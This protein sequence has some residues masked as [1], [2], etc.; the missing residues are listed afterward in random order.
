MASKN[1]QEKVLQ[2][3]LD[4]YNFESQSFKLTY[5][6]RYCMKKLL[7]FGSLASLLSGCANFGNGELTGVQNR[8]FFEEV[9]PMG[10]QFCRSGSYQMGPN[11]QDV[12]W[13][14]TAE[15]KT[16]SV[17]AFWIDQ[18][19]IT[20][21]EY[22]QFVYWVKDSIALKLLGELDEERYL[23][24]T[25]EFEEEVTP[26]FI[27]W[28]S[29]VEW[30]SADEEVR[31]AL[32]PM[33]LP[34]GE[35]FYRQ[36]QIDTRKLNFEY[37]WIDMR[38]AARKNY[39]G[40]ENRT[41][42]NYETQ[43]YDG[44]II[45]YSKGATRG[46]SVEVK[47]RSSYIMH[48]IINVYPD[49]LVWISDFTYSFNEPNAKA[50]FWHPVYDHYPVVGVTWRQARAFS[51]WRTNLLNSYLNEQEEP[52]V[53]DFRLPTESEWE[54]AAR[55]GQ[56]SSMYPW[57]GPYATNYKGCYIANFKP[58]RGNYP[59]DGGLHTVIVANNDPNDWGIYDMAGNVAEWTSNAFDESAYSFTDDLNP[60]Y[61]Y[62]TKPNDQPE[63]KR[64][65][66]RGGSWKDVA[67]YMQCGTRTYEYEDTAKSYIGFRNVRDFLGHDFMDGGT[68]SQIY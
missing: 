49:T 19:E 13:A 53:Q 48:D 66:I 3:V 14:M 37:Y 63:K 52:I 31:E 55:G 64:K 39:F 35:R 8:P 56:K 9:Q 20:N 26:P 16:V 25:N 24:T 65:V 30:Y 17:K 27:N 68:G 7:I 46:E 1:K 67:M 43:K 36:K 15:Q 34:E 28:D 12:T 41:A 4:F 29:K 11:D 42:W 59:A 38:Q 21:N 44:E 58:M 33:Y 18:T 62:E 2:E 10:M 61:L 40:N 50:Y 23:I 22:R 47:D 51:I 54:Y 45:D 6:R 5:I 60:D 57:G 32:N